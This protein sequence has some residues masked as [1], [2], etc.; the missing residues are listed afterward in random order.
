M[1]TSE[2]SLLITSQDPEKNS[3]SQ[4]G[5]SRRKV[6][7][8]TCAAV[9]VGLIVNQSLS[10]QVKS[11]NNELVK[12]GF[13]QSLWM[14]QPQS[15]FTWRKIPSLQVGQSSSKIIGLTVSPSG[16]IYATASQLV[17]GDEAKRGFVYSANSSSWEKM[18][19]NFQ[20]EGIRFD[21]YGSYYLL[22]QN[23]NVFSEN[24]STDIVLNNIQD[25]QVSQSNVF[26]AIE[27]NHNDL[28]FGNES[29]GIK[30]NIYPANTFKKIQLRN[31]SPLLLTHQGSIANYTDEHECLLDFS[32]GIDRSIWALNCSQDNSTGSELLK[33]NSVNKTWDLIEGIKG[34]KIAA[35]NEIS[36]AVLDVQGNIYISQS[37][38]ENVDPSSPVQPDQ[39]DF[40]ISSQ[41]FN[42]SVKISYLQ[43]ILPQD[44]QYKGAIICYRFTGG[45]E[46]GLF[47]RECDD[48]GP[49]F[50]V[51]QT[52]GYG[53]GYGQGISIF[54]GYTQKGWN[55]QT[56]QGGRIEDKDAFL[57]SF[58]QKLK[59]PISPFSTRALQVYE[60]EGPQFGNFDLVINGM[61]LTVGPLSEYLL[62][63][64]A[65]QEARQFWNQKNSRQLDIYEIFILKK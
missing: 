26:H 10:T 39:P 11:D 47:H 20:F 62:P 19:S 18:N 30:L 58:D 56:S 38:Q 64:E 21:N 6:L 36:V 42:D 31:N 51:T 13:L 57:F 33:W 35:Y 16:D 25:F 37:T 2:K 22:D 8:S 40:L 1:Q 55:S 32:V 59:L 7:L 65:S 34:V 15:N 14:E 49:A 60:R 54:G 46:F 27:K 61:Y 3:R 12:N 43:S 52:K 17:F 23:N 9:A 63:K 24:G 29:S 4:T 5:F 44:Q 41:I 48:Q 45:Q 53:K 28:H 50:V